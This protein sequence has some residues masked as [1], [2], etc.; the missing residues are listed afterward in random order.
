MASGSNDRDTLSKLLE[1]GTVAEYQSEF[2]ILINR[3]MGISENLLKSFYI[4]KLKSN[5]ERALLRSN[6]TTLGEAFSLA[7]ATEARFTN[8]QLWELLRS[9]PTTLGEAFSLA[10]ITRK[11][12]YNTHKTL[13]PPT[14]AAVHLTSSPL[15]STSPPAANLLQGTPF[16][17]RFNRDAMSSFRSIENDV[18]KIST[19]V[20]ITNFPDESSAKD[21]FHACNVYGHVVDSYIPNKRA[22]NG[23][24]FGF[25]RFINV[26]SEDRLINNLCT[27]WM[28]RHKL[29]ANISRFQR[30]NNT[31]GNKAGGIKPNNTSRNSFVPSKGPGDTKNSNSYAKVVSGIRANVGDCVENSPALVLDDGCLMTSKF[32]NSLFG[33]VKEFAS[34]AN[35]KLSLEN[36]GFADIHIQY[37]GEFWILLKFNNPETCKK[38]RNNVSVGSWFSVLKDADIDF[39]CDKR[40]AWVETEGIPFKLWTENTFTRIASRWGVLLSVDDEEESCF[41]SKRLCV[42]TSNPRSI[43]EDFK[44]IFRGKVHWIRAKETPGWVPDFANEIRDEEYDDVL[45]NDDGDKNHRS[46]FF[47]EE[48]E[49][50]DGQEHQSKEDPIDED[51]VEEGEVKIAKEKSED[52]FGIYHI[53]KNKK[54]NTKGIDNSSSYTHPPG[55]SHVKAQEDVQEMNNINDQVDENADDSINNIKEPAKPKHKDEVCDS[56]SSGYF[57]KSEAPKTGGSILQLLDDVVKVGQVMGYKMEGCINNM[58]EIIEAQGVEEVFR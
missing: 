41:H 49:V 2:E 57:K 10:R 17:P 47:G 56:V 42:H 48:E 27:V 26:F 11:H 36:E 35:I 51:F 13:R 40:I 4:S 24:K 12:I 46:N 22:K 28:G 14:T 38:F 1:M 7:R 30:N 5:L 43:S 32:P 55:F 3:V 18:A 53:L 50:K 52:P 58:S 21:L 45:S 37:L 9:N 34:L 6:P 20:Y 39:H 33:R 31:G 8:L 19:T 29:Y 23:K 54:N 16:N 44:I 25:V 15:S